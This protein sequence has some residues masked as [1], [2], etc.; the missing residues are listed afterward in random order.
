MKIRILVPVAL[1]TLTASGLFAETANSGKT[2][3]IDLAMRNL[4][5]KPGD[6]F[7]EYANGGWRKAAEIPPDRA[8][9]GVAFEVFQKAEKRN[10]DLVREAGAGNPKPGTPQR[11]IADYYAAYMDTA[12][13]EKR[14]LDPLKAA[15]E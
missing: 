9:I 13:I 15:L 5:V 12:G 2:I 10:A 8:T 1:M 3:G 11:M 14:G 7:E 6:D 4:A